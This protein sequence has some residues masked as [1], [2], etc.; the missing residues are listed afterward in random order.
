M[1]RV[2]RALCHSRPDLG[3]HALGKSFRCLQWLSGWISVKFAFPSTLTHTVI[4]SFPQSPSLKRENVCAHGYSGSRAD[5]GC[6]GRSMRQRRLVQAS[7]DAEAGHTRRPSSFRYRQVVQFGKRRNPTLPGRRRRQ[8]TT[9]RKSTTT[10]R[11][12][13]PDDAQSRSVDRPPAPAPW[14]RSRILYVAGRAGNHGA[15]G[16]E[17]HQSGN[18]RAAAA[19]RREERTMEIW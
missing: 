3:Q 10:R 1:P 18:R 5:R 17:R 12:R 8:R 15:A 14:S 19:G 2:R 11:K 16:R 4:A 13:A 7:A 9:P 6:D